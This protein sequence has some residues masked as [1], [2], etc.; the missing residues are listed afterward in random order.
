MKP[1]SISYIVIIGDNFTG[2]STTN[3]N[4]VLPL[5]NDLHNKSWSDHI[6]AR[7]V[8]EFMPTQFEDKENL[9][10]TT[11]IS[12]DVVRNY[13]V[14]E[15]TAHDYRWISRFFSRLTLSTLTTIREKLLAYDEA[16]KLSK[17]HKKQTL[18]VEW[19][20]ANDLISINA[21]PS[22]IE[23]NRAI[24]ARIANAEQ[25]IKAGYHHFVLF[26]LPD[27]SLAPRYQAWSVSE[28]ERINAHDC[29]R[30]F[31]SELMKAC[32]ELNEVYPHCSINVFDINKIV[33][34]VYEDP[35]KYGFNKSKPKTAYMHSPNACKINKDGNSPP[36][37]HNMF[38]DDIHL[39]TPMH[40]ELSTRFYERYRHEYLFSEPKI[41]GGQ[42]QELDISDVDLRTAFIIKYKAKLEEDEFRLFSK[43]KHID[44]KYKTAS[45]EEILRKAL[46]EAGSLS[47]EVITELQWV[48]NEGNLNLNIPTLKTALAHI[49]FEKTKEASAH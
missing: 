1:K 40:A 47:H 41:E 23:V 29:S 33:M 16:H 45:L 12:N 46:Y 10:T 44:I 11:D 8:S 30:Y 27:L 42:E 17:P 15:L 5:L 38:E 6:S 13:A 14:G 2:S 20:G 37:R 18:I 25:L 28:V 22:K 48:D 31:N 4:K 19:S 21:H 39:S 7:F 36:P 34:D 26:N 49:K 35:E 9:A 32:K 24:K 43:P 3:S